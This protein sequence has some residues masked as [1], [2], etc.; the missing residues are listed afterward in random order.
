MKKKGY[1]ICDSSENIPYITINWT[2]ISF[3]RALNILYTF[4][5]IFLT[6]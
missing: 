6:M 5:K 2:K 4:C 1:R 3:K